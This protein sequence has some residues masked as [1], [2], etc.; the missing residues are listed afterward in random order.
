MWNDV[1]DLRTF[2]GTGTGLVA[3]R[4]IR[5]RLRAMW[6]DVKDLDMVGF[7][8][9]APFL[10]LFNGEA[11][12]AVAL[13]PVQQGVWAWPTDGPVAVA[14]TEEAHLPLADLSVDRM[15]LIHALE[16][17]EA[18]RAMLREVWRVMA[19][20]GRLIVVTPSRRGLWARME[21]TPFG[22]GRP[23]T[24]GQLKRTLKEAMFAP[25]RVENA[26]FFPPL[27]SRWLLKAA[28]AVE[29]VG[30]RWL[31]PLAGVMLAEARKDTLAAIPVGEA[32]G[33]RTVPIPV[34]PAAAARK[35]ERRA[36]AGGPVRPPRRAG[37]GTCPR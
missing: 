19:D 15:L 2:Y 6:P 9:A 30:R 17:S 24:E 12:R 32:A 28:P 18:L 34:A 10:R 36:P 13:M 1:S 3:R 31:K 20:D 26:L 27:R 5:R 37:G 7:G 25:E 21:R 14:L 33:R 8:Y 29:R 22:H 11:R 4:L 35:A 23:F 16:A